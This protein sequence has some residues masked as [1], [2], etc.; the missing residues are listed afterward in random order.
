MLLFF[1][2]FSNSASLLAVVEIDVHLAHVLVV[3]PVLVHERSIEATIRLP[4]AL[5]RLVVPVRIPELEIS[6]LLVIGAKDIVPAHLA[7]IKTSEAGAKDVNGGC[8]K[9]VEGLLVLL[10]VRV[11]VFVSSLDINPDLAVG[12]IVLTNVLVHASH[13]I[14]N[15]TAVGSG[16]HVQID[17]LHASSPSTLNRLRTVGVNRI[18]GTVASHN[19]K[20]VALVPDAFPRF[21]LPQMRNINA[22]KSLH[23]NSS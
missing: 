22:N 12:D 19:R 15:I 2:F 21:R 8:A 10:L 1:F 16:V 18:R 6:P 20:F 23:S 9:N 13:L 4:V 5:S 3:T 14:G 7:D 11:P 17:V